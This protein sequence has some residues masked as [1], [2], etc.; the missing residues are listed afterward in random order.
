MCLNLKKHKE[1]IKDQ[2]PYHMFTKP[3]CLSKD[4]WINTQYACFEEHCEL[5]S[6]YWGVF[7]NED[8]I[9]DLDQLPCEDS[10]T[11]IEKF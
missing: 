6:W 7:F 3:V 11:F 5:C 10:A 9:I 4:L 2:P 8:A 1:Y